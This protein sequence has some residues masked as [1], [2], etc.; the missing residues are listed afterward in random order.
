MTFVEES[1]A[2]TGGIAHPFGAARRRGFGWRRRAGI[3]I[4][5]TQTH[6]EAT[7]DPLV[8]V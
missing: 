8:E 7:T 1:T 5:F 3:D 4:S 2:I 6:P